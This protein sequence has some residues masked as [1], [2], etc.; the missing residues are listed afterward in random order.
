MAKGGSVDA[1]VARVEVGRQGLNKVGGG[2]VE[3]MAAMGLEV[4]GW[5]A[6]A[7]MEVEGMVEVVVGNGA[8][9]RGGSG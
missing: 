4:W 2:G 8:E 6:A 1:A 3:T 9:G 5:A 7:G